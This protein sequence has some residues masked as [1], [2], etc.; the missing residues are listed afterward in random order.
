MN[1]C[2]VT[3]ATT[4]A[5]VLAIGG[6]VRPLGAIHIYECVTDSK[7]DCK[8]VYDGAIYPLGGH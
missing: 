8:E 7:L 6:Q 1:N 3:P 5:K 2:T 4:K